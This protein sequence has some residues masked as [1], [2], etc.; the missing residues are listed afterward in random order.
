M[1][2]FCKL[3]MG[4]CFGI[5][6]M[7]T[8]LGLLISLLPVSCV[9]ADPVPA[10]VNTQS[11][12]HLKGRVL[13]AALDPTTGCISGLSLTGD[14]NQMNWVHYGTEWGSGW[15]DLE[16]KRVDWTL[17]NFQS[18]GPISA[19]STYTAGPVT[20]T[21]VRTFDYR[22]SLKESYTFTNTSA[23]TVTIPEDGLGIGI[24]FNDSYA[25]GAS[26]CLTGRCNAHIWCADNTVY[27]CAT[28]MG[29]VPPGL[30]LV[31]TQ[32]SVSGYS[33]ENTRSSDDRGTIILHPA[34]MTLAAGASS[35]VSWVLLAHAGWDDFYRKAAAIP[36]FVRMTA[37]K[38]TFELGRQCYCQR[39]IYGGDQTASERRWTPHRVQTPWSLPHGDLSARLLRRT[40]RFFRRPG[41]VN[42]SSGLRHASAD[43]S[44]RRPCEVHRGT[45]TAQR[46]GYSA[47]RRLSGLRQR[48]RPADRRCGGR[49]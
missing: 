43:G 9:M 33:I 19:T 27:V 37:S 11:P 20:V 22:Q 36:A 45:S 30:G 34:P 44:D 26:V 25:G 48:H 1:Q 41:C 31:L 14:P 16:N 3:K 7:L 18:T 21:V 5:T 8:T 6:A 12:I 42:L 39:H 38:Y 35:T 4:G 2:T 23:A 40:R 32:G 13:D 47:G 29:G 24:P 28:R 49:S 10:P 46:A 15:I 17:S